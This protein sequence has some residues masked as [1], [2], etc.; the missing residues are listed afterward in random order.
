MHFS[1]GGAADWWASA[2]LERPATNPI[3]QE[4]QLLSL[5]RKCATLAQNGFQ[6]RLMLA[7]IGERR[8][9]EDNRLPRRL[10]TQ[11]GQFYSSTEVRRTITAMG[12]CRLH[13]RGLFP[14]PRTS[15]CTQKV[16]NRKDSPFVETGTRATSCSAMLY[17]ENLTCR[18][19]TNNSLGRSIRRV[20]KAAKARASTG[21]R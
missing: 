20:S 5:E 10:F 21:R 1:N 8:E 6:L 12:D 13:A 11:F 9:V 3:T 19:K 2:L 18:T 16:H 4:L 15:H 7:R 17:L 14:A